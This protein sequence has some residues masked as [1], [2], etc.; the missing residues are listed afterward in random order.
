MARTDLLITRFRHENESWKR[1][2]GFFREENINLKTR[3]SDLLK[4]TKENNGDFLE[5]LEYFQN[6]FLKEDEIIR[7]LHEE[8]SEQDKLLLR[9]LYEDGE[10]IKEVQKKQKKIR[11]QLENTE[12]E[13]YQLKSEFNT[14]LGEII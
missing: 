9:D 10:L 13:F 2:L 8:I 11:R 1:I 6:L 7:F 5:Q 4:N 3:L 14:Y 12:R